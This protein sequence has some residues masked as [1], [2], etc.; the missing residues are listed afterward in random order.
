MLIASGGNPKSANYNWMRALGHT[1]AEP[2]PSLFT[3]NVPN[4]PLNELMGVSVPQV[5][6]VLAGEKL[7]YE[8][9]LRESFGMS[10]SEAKLPFSAGSLFLEAR[11]SSRTFVR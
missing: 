4:S 6:V 7:Q 3:F 8:G 10:G 2:V 5:R 11:S 1:V 9:P